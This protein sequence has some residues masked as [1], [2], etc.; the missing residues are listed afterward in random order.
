MVIAPGTG[1]MFEAKPQ[2]TEVPADVV[3]AILA[4]A[5]SDLEMLYEGKVWKLPAYR[6][7][8]PGEQLVDMFLEAIGTIP[9]DA[10]IIDWGCG[11]GRASKKL[12]EAGFDVTMVD[13]ASNCLDDDVAELAK[14]N[15]KLRFIKHDLTKKCDLMADFGYCTDVMEH[16]PEDGIDKV[17]GNILLCSKNVFFQISTQKDGFGGH[18]DIDEDLHLTVHGYFW[19]LQQFHDQATIILRSQDNGGNVIF[20]VTGYGQ[21]MF[22]WEDAKVNIPKEQRRENI[23]ANSKLGLQQVMPHQAQDIEVM[24]LCGGPSID[25]FKD[26]IIEKREGGMPLITVNGSYHKAIEWGLSPSL[27]CMVDGREFMRRFV[28]QVPGYTDHTKYVISSHCNPEVFVGL[29]KERTYI[30]TVA[31]GYDDMDAVKAHYGEMYKDFWPCPGGSTVTLRALCLLRML[32]FSK[33][34]VYGMDSCNMDGKHHAYEQE[35]NDDGRVTDMI[36]GRGTEYE[37]VFRC[38]P[39][40]VYQATEFLQMVPRVLM[41]CDLIVY[42]DG[43][44]AY[45]INTAAEMDSDIFADS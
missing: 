37:K 39:W 14:N 45:M 35:E 2:D 42:G 40:H 5:P 34:H 13:F 17:L 3:A 7:F 4:N 38:E 18:P 23:I 30:W 33:I 41:D 32:G 1:K 9:K 10:T 25:E 20:Y 27:Q 11:T 22:R 8:S 16:I 29:P 31:V 21:H 28:E 15:D 36:V 12:Y 26:D 6:D 43:M 24:L 44:I 19:W